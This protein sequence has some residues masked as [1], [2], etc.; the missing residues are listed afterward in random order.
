MKFG[1]VFPQIE[2]GHDPVALRNYAQA[3]EEFGYSHLLAYD[4]ILGANP[5]RP[6]GWR[7]PY[8]YNNPFLEP[9][10][11]FSYLA[12]LTQRLEFTTG[13]LILPQRQTVLVAKQAATLDAL[14]GGGRLRLGLGLGWNAVEYEALNEKFSNRGRRIEEQIEVLK[15]LWADPLVKFEGRWHHIPDAGLNPLPVQRKIPLWFGG[16][17]ERVLRRVAKYADGWMPNYRKAADIQP[18]L[19]LLDK[20]LAAEERAR[21]DIGLEAR[22][23]FGEGDPSVWTQTLEEWRKVG[24]THITIN[25]MGVGFD[26]PQKHIKAIK[27]FAEE[28][29][30]GK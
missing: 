24:V 9:F 19:E 16:H 12:P 30:L 22:M 17:H 6:G 21:K 8:T 26:T 28:M 29:G 23:Q 13:I 5:E 2:F 25:T 4:H 20:F 10:V 7:G 3:A 27:V 15:K 18:H 11:L 1:V 14:T